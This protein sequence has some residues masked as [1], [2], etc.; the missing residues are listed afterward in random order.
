VWYDSVVIVP[1]RHANQPRPR[2]DMPDESPAELTFEQALAQLE[3]IVRRL[4][5]GQLGLGE[6]LA[7]YEAGVRHLKQCYA[8]LEE[9]ERK[10]ELLA[11][12][13]AAGNPV[14]RPFDDAQLALEDK[15]DQ[16][17][18]RRTAKPAR[19]EPPKRENIEDAPGLFELG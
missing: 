19:P 15:A 4:E 9:A 12:I 17:S 13:D 7:Q 16:R 3:L 10:I 2:A 8:A 18:K 11:G 6:A 5:E 14:T 1:S